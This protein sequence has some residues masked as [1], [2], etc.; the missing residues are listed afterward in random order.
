MRAPN[1]HLARI[2]YAGV[3]GPI[4]FDPSQDIVG[5]LD[6]ILLDWPRTSGPEDPEKALDRDPDGSVLARI[7]LAP[8]GLTASSRYLDTPMT[9]LT[10][11]SAACCLVA[12]LSQGFVDGAS[13]ALALHCGAV[14]INGRLVALTGQHR[15]GKSTLVSRLTAEPDLRVFCDDMLPILSDGQAMA[16]GV[17]PRLRLPLPPTA[18]LQF[19]AHVARWTGPQDDRYAYLCAPGRAA[20]G[21][22]APLSAIIVLDRRDDMPAS[23][24]HLPPDDALRNVLAR[25]MSEMDSAELAFDRL[26]TL[27]RDVISLRLVYSD[28]EDAVALLRRAFGGASPIDPTLSIRPEITFDAEP[29]AAPSPKL[30]TLDRIWQKDPKVVLR[31]VGQSH[32]LWTT[33]G[34]EIWQMNPLATAIWTLLEIPASAHDLTE[35]LAEVFTDQPYQRV[36]DDVAALL[37]QLQHNGLVRPLE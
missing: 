9:G 2:D 36:L 6:Q 5:L 1:T 13:D 27:V 20:H 25:N 32:F 17:A 10:P 28:L 34:R 19:R 18:S 31:R 7:D 33:E 29:S 30:V 23:F 11:T 24:H 37:A 8:K 26:H 16:L 21:T 3:T 4:M 35:A 15:A 12:D 22:K 14:Q